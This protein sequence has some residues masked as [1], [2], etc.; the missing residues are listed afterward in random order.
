MRKNYTFKLLVLTISTLMNFMT[1]QTNAQTELLIRCDD[2]GMCHTVN[3]AAK[4]LSETD[5]PFSTS[6]MFACPWYKEAVEILKVN[7]QISVGIHLVLNSEWKNY[8][9]GPV[10]GSEAVPS[11]V[12]GNG[13]FYESEADFSNGGY[14]LNEVETELR[15]QIERALHSGLQI[16]YVDEHMG[17]AVSTPE[18]RV[19]VE[20]LAKEYKLGISMYFNENYQTL[21]D[22]EPENKS[23]R[24]L[25]VV[26]S[27]KANEV[28]LLVIHLGMESGEM[29]A[30]IDMNNPDD[31]YRVAQHRQAELDALCSGKFEK[32]VQKNNVKF[33]TYKELISKVGLKVMCRPA[34]SEY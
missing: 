23:S 27:L 1:P 26:D 10:V 14:K 8:K 28:N 34:V 17:T 11:L 29:E 31:P 19:I 3:M 33:T 7:P 9:W 32:A 18:L 21:W 25:E 20:K 12:D 5:I 6:V 2:I 22:I 30:L 15:A 13:Y 16:D 4:K 24:L